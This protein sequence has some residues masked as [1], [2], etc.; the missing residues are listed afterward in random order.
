MCS[1][2]SSLHSPPAR[3]RATYLLPSLY[4]QF[5]TTLLVCL[6]LKLFSGDWFMVCNLFHFPFCLLQ[7]MLLLKRCFTSFY[8]AF[9][10]H[11]L[12]ASDVPLCVWAGHSGAK[13]VSFWTQALHLPGV[14]GEEENHNW[15]CDCSTELARGFRA[16]ALV[17][18]AGAHWVLAAAQPLSCSKS[19][20]AMTPTKAK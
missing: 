20:I 15:N 3:A 17:W 6:V 16:A 2:C 14:G 13:P 12:K 4:L 8:V 18:S 1:A 5:L 7:V 10:Q 11:W 19:T 9:I